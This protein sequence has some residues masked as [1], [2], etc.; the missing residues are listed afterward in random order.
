MPKVGFSADSVASSTPPE[1]L[2]SALAPCGLSVCGV[3][4]L[5]LGKHEGRESVYLCVGEQQGAQHYTSGAPK[6]R[7]GRNVAWLHCRSDIRGDAHVRPGSC[8]GAG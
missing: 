1:V 7:K 8:P 2:S 3:C 4:A 6:E 5:V